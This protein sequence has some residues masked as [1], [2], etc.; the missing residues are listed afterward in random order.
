MIR[1]DGGDADPDGDPTLNVLFSLD[2]YDHGS[3]GAEASAQ[4]LARYLAQRGHRVDVLQRGESET[5]YDDGPVR[6]Y[7]RPLPAGG[8]LESRQRRAAE[9][10][11]IWR[12]RLDQ[13]L[14]ERGAD[15]IVTHAQLVPAS[16]DAAR[17]HDI[18]VAAFVRA[19]RPFCPMQFKNRDPLRE[20]T[21]G[22]LEC[23]PWY[24]RVRAAALRRELEVQQRAL[25][26]AT[27]VFANS[28][29]VQDV[30]RKFLGIDAEVVYPAVDLSGA[31]EAR[32]EEQGDAVLFVKPQL[33]KGFPIFLEVARR[34]PDTRFR[35]AGKASARVQRRL[36]ALANVEMLGWVRNMDRAYARARVLM[37]P[38][39]WPEPFGR[40]FVEAAAHGVPAVA[41]ARGGIPEAVGDG[42]ILVDD[43]FAAER[44][45]AALHEISEPAAWAGY[46]ANG[47]EHAKRFTIDVSGAAFVAGI[48][49]STGLTL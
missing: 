4:G 14:R 25:K 23:L 33:V 31:E 3:G 34:M 19:Y 7:T 26:G 40:V 47:R 22:C 38:S 42:G 24:R 11:R 9:W 30:I 15:L 2:N 5:A 43:I 13:R 12:E 46:S 36:G 20:C 32:R 49:K 18:P 35:V 48:Q 37:G 1:R 17:A 16:V 6:V 28:R 10:S 21:G 39:I 29:Y 27:A 41:S 8:P 45:V 44:W